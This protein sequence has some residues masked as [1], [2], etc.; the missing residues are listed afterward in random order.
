[1]AKCT[2]PAVTNAALDPALRWSS[3]GATAAWA[4]VMANWRADPD[5]GGLRLSQRASDFFHDSENM[6]CGVTAD[7][8]GCDTTVQCNGV[9]YPDG[10]FILNSFEQVNRVSA[11][12]PFRV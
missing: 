6:L 3:V 11:A 4:A 9:S 1:M 10:Y 12:L 7:H 2:D 5:H 8:N